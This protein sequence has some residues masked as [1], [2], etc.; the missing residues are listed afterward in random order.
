MPAK[1]DKAEVKHIERLKA[2][3]KPLIAQ[4]GLTT[5]DDALHQGLRKAIEDCSTS[6]DRMLKEKGKPTIHSCRDTYATRMLALGVS[7]GE[8]SQLLG[9]ASL[10]QTIKY[11]RFERRATASKARELMDAH[12]GHTSGHTY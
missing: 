6:T 8:V 12:T 4:D 2:L 1:I 7:L 9:H 5:D 3:L 11:A 10:Q